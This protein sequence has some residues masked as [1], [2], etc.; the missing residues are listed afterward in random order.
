MIDSITQLGLVLP[1]F[2]GHGRDDAFDTDRMAALAPAGFSLATDV[3]EWLVRRGVPFRVAHELAGAC[4]RAAEPRGSSCRTSRT[5][6]S[7]RS[8]PSSPPGARG[9]RRRRIARLPGRARR[10]GPG[11]GGRAARAARPPD[12]RARGWAL[13]P[14]TPVARASATTTAANG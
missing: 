4:V 10:D 3:A 5:T 6:S 7:P 13:T 11:A 1:A 8:R 9:P 2:T 14:V 12:R